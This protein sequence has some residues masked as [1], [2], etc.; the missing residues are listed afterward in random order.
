MKKS[1]GAGGFAA[2]SGLRRELQGQAEKRKEEELLRQKAEAER[3]AQANMFQAEMERLGI[4]GEDLRG[5]R[6]MH[7]TP[8]P[9]PVP[10]QRLRDEKAVLQD[11]L[12]D[13]IS[14]EHL[15]D[16]DENLSYRAPQVAPDVPR[17]LRRGV[18]AIKGCLDLHGF[19]SDEA[20][21]TLAAFLTEQR[22]K[23]NRVVRIIH[24][25]GYGSVGRK[26]VLKERVPRWLAQRQDVLAFVQA[27][28]N[29]G[30]SGALLVLL[31]A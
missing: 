22:K 10:V 7:Q 25:K 19:T 14:I 21:V 28:D 3:R 30:G 5:E 18:W 11:S 26:S 2:L 23:G 16:S 1:E 4:K 27:P 9:A 17:K 15:L 24:G 13:E 20:R 8:R 12:S 6:V 29:D 31:A